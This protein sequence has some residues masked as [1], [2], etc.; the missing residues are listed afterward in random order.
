LYE[1]L[2]LILAAGILQ[3]RSAVHWPKN[4]WDRFRAS[5]PEIAVLTPVKVSHVFKLID[6]YDH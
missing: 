2:Q 5:P 3:R 4:E 1:L 6:L